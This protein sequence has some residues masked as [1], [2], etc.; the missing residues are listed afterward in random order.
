[1]RLSKQQ[2]TTAGLK[3]SGNIKQGAQ[4]NARALRVRN[5]TMIE[6]CILV[7]GKPVLMKTCAEIKR[8]TVCLKAIIISPLG[9]IR[10]ANM[11]LYPKGLRPRTVLGIVRAIQHAGINVLGEDGRL[12]DTLEISICKV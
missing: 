7:Q 2:S 5:V 11:N 8:V 12:S 4:R 1:M 6:H 9:I 10:L 3:R